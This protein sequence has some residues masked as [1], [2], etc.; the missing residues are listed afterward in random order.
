MSP[1]NGA[2]EVPTRPFDLAK[3]ELRIE[4]DMRLSDQGRSWKIDGALND[5]LIS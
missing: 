1:T 3:P 4:G 5:G 2:P